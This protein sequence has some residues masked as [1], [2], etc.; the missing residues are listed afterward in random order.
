MWSVPK[1]SFRQ[2]TGILLPKEGKV[3]LGVYFGFSFISP[4]LPSFKT[5]IT[6]TSF[7]V[8][9]DGISSLGCIAVKF[10]L[11]AVNLV[12]LRITRIFLLNFYG[13]SGT[14]DICCTFKWLDFLLILDWN[15]HF[16]LGTNIL[17]ARPFT[18]SLKV[19]GAATTLHVFGMR[20]W[21]CGYQ[22]PQRM[23]T[24]F[25]AIFLVLWN[26]LPAGWQN[27]LISC[28][29]SL[30]TSWRCFQSSSLSCGARD[31]LMML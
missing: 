27:S 18:Q 16:T 21:E 23:T 13:W 28:D 15:I 2:R 30:L 19:A 22:C 10:E 5:Q 25:T 12:T 26:F 8:S 9:V 6:L 31:F 4:P 17:F 20:G 11:T 29:C 14:V 1:F 3:T 7:G 24:S